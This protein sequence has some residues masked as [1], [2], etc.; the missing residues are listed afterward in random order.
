M[1]IK[2]FELEYRILLGASSLDS[3]MITVNCMINRRACLG[4]LVGLGV[5]ASRPCVRAQ[6]VRPFCRYSLEDGWT[7]TGPREY[8][9]RQ[10]RPTGDPSG[11]PQVVDRIRQVLSFTTSFE[12]FIS[13]SENN[14]FAIVANGR[15]LLVVD[16]DP[17]SMSSPI[18]GGHL[19]P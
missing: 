15:K 1:K 14:A 12:I 8:I 16:V 3:H 4:G 13:M 11:V 18:G 17:K 2:R 6:S 5:F 7:D 19:Q 10:A 9:T